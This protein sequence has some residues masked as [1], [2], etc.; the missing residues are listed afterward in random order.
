[1]RDDFK[2]PGSLSNRL[3]LA[4]TSASSEEYVHILRLGTSIKRSDMSNP[5]Y[6]AR[7]DF[8]DMRI[9]ESLIIRAEAMQRHLKKEGVHNYNYAHKGDTIDFMFSSL[10]D[11]NLARILFMQDRSYRVGLTP[12]NPKASLKDIGNIALAFQQEFFERGLSNEI[13]IVI[14][15]KARKIWADAANPRALVE[16][17]GNEYEL[18]PTLSNP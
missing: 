13:K 16:L 3:R 8:E 12:E 6:S 7:A 1:M 15:S 18:T 2:K 11:L 5:S 4:S 10:F 9:R 14:D 17:V